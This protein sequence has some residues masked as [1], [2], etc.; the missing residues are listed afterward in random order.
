MNSLKINNLQLK[1]IDSNKFMQLNEVL[2]N[3]R[4]LQRNIL[5]I[6]R[7]SKHNLTTFNNVHITRYLSD[8]IENLLNGS[9][10]NK[11]QFDILNDTEKIILT[12]VLSLAN[13]TKMNYFNI[14]QV[15]EIL[16][17]QMRK[18]ENEINKNAKN[19]T[20]QQIADLKQIL[21]ALQDL[22]ILSLVDRNAYLNQLTQL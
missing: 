9:T 8:L 14:E 19:V 10:I 3:N 11:Q 5:S 13:I 4:L 22:K 12:R 1:P 2:I 7:L 16:I 21:N 15:K 17:K 6:K 20:P 18:I